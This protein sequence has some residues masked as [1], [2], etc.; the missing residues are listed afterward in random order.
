MSSPRSSDLSR[1]T[2]LLVLGA[3]VLILYFARELLIPLAF[4]LT[5]AFLLAPAVNRLEHLRIPRIPAVALT[6]ILAFAALCS[7]GYVVTRQLLN[8]AR[9]LPAYRLTIQKHLVSVHS[10]AEQS[11]E[12]AL[13]AVEGIGEDLTHP[14]PKAASS[15]IL[16]LPPEQAQP[17]RLVDPSRSQLQSS[18]EMLFRF[19]RPI[20]TLGVILVFTIYLL[21][22][23]E[24]LRHRILLLAGIGRISVMT[25]ALQDAATRISQ[26]LVMQVAVN[27]AY[28]VLFGSGL[29]LIGIPDATLW[30]ALAGLLRIIPY[31]GTATGLLFPL[32]ISIA[33]F[34][35]WL[36]P[37]LILALFFTL[38][39]SATNF[40]E[41]WLYSSRTGISSLALLTMAIF[42][43][44]LW[45]WP[46]LILSTPLTVCFVV[47]GRYVPQMSFLHTL[48][49]A[50]AEL[51]P[52]AHFY[53]RLLALDQR[54]AREVANKFLCGKPLAQL[55]DEIFI[56]ALR[57]VEQDRHAGTLDDTRSNFF[58]LSIGE[59][60]SELTDYHQAIPLPLTAFPSIIPP[61]DAGAGRGAGAGAGAPGI[62]SDAWV[63]ATST[64]SYKHAEHPAAPAH[65]SGKWISRV[66]ASAQNH[67]L[68]FRGPSIP[69]SPAP[70]PG[71]P[72]IDSDAWVSTPPAEPSAAAAPSPTPHP[73]TPRNDFAVICIS[74]SDQADELTS[75][76]L[77]QLIE[78]D[79]HPTLLLSASS[80]SREV[81]DG[82]AKE[83]NTVIFIS[84]LPPFAFSQARATCQRVRTHLPHN[85]IVIGFWENPD[86]TTQATG[87]NPDPSSNYLPDHMIERFG[88]GRPTLV[89]NTLAQALAQI[90]QWQRQPSPAP[91]THPASYPHHQPPTVTPAPTAASN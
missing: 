88:S 70:T 9:D 19:L 44:L 32:F 78:R 91:Y 30:G 29:Y 63:S 86:D 26:Y 38:E 58:F 53:E 17:V 28:G 85:R 56:P 84:A 23:R 10:P 51:S 57:L 49:G 66:L 47:L 72:G 73:P 82:L 71:A 65:A 4:A 40:V 45:G 16:L 25:E 54:E 55:Y 15:D 21:M 14:Q 12:A 39:L 50:D 8:V 89:V 41:P 42:W 27:A 33:V 37:L 36:P 62:D 13:A 61:P 1:L 3:I 22:K 68:R 75:N 64:A 81:L 59:L 48:L 43:A 90:E 31:V 18:A 35:S 7:V 11:F 60:I 6:V 77:A 87:Q 34:S 52:E 67:T 80:I 79:G 20:G 76:M 24:D 46:G 83:P 74:A 5:L 2:P 69:P